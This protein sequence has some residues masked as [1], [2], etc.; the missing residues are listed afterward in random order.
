[1]ECVPAVRSCEV[2]RS[3]NGRMRMNTWMF[4]ETPPR[5]RGGGGCADA[6]AFEDAVVVSGLAAA[7]LVSDM[8]MS[9]LLVDE[10]RG[11]GLV[12]L[13]FPVWIR[14]SPR[15][16]CFKAVSRATDEE[17]GSDGALATAASTSSS[18][19]ISSQ[20]CCTPGL[21]H[22]WPQRHAGRDAGFVA[23][24]MVDG[25][26]MTEGGISNQRQEECCLNVQAGSRPK[27]VHMQ[28]HTPSY[29]WKCKGI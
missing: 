9:S 4:S 8:V 24:V 29:P 16:C 20:K 13:F 6:T 27:R 1:M 3:I 17:T 23:M 15:C 21:D 11:S 19:S 14:P 26:A 28:A 2:S 7:L 18:R 25:S 5:R 12:K 10:D 22:D